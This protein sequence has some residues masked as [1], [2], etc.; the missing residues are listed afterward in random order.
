MQLVVPVFLQE[1]EVLGFD[2]QRA[3]QVLG[4]SDLF[5]SGPLFA[6]VRHFDGPVGELDASAEFSVVPANK[7]GSSR[8]LFD[9]RLKLFGGLIGLGLFLARM[10]FVDE[11][12]GFFN[13]FLDFL[14]DQFLNFFVSF[15]L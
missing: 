12:N 11:F 13:L 9:L 3:A 7:L 5:K 8:G 1:D 2:F 4:D 15:A 6:E 10:L 14:L